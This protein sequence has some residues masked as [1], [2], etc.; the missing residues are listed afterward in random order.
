[1][2]VGVLKTEDEI[3]IGMIDQGSH[4]LKN[5]VRRR[6]V[7]PMNETELSARLHLKRVKSSCH[8]GVNHPVF[9]CFGRNAFFRVT[10][11][12]PENGSVK[13]VFARRD[14]DACKVRIGNNQF[15]HAFSEVVNGR[16]VVGIVRDAILAIDSISEDVP[17]NDIE[18]DVSRFAISHDIAPK[19]Y[20]LIN[21]HRLD[22]FKI[23]RT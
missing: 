20:F 14:A 2:R 12:R 4:F 17:G 10:I 21:G 11:A 7:L 19:G 22:R 23:T 18:I 6:F 15:F 3:N 9:F 16:L 13:H 1:M 5:H 8:V